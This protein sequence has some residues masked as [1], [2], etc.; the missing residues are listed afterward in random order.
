MRQLP[1]VRLL[2]NQ[3]LVTF[4]T[5]VLGDAFPWTID[6]NSS[7]RSDRCGS[8]TSDREGHQA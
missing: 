5:I 3:L 4:T 8:R 2:H 1:R 6:R 7:M